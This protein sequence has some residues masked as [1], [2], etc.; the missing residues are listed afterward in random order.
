MILK[1]LP[2]LLILRAL[3]I[4]NK[5]KQQSGFDKNSKKTC[6][7][8]IVE[9]II[10]IVLF[11]VLVPTSLVIFVSA[12]KIVGQSYIQNQAAV[13]LGENNDILRYMRNLNFDLLVNGTFYMIRNP[14]TGSWLVKSDLPD[15]DIFERRI[16]VSNALRHTDTH[17]IY[18]DGDIGDS[19]EDSDTKKI[20]INVVWAPDYMPLDLLTHTLY[21]TDWQKVITYP[22][23]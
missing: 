6:G 14:G 19:Y 12:R 10:V 21:V 23:V 5:N 16:I 13:T 7:I 2:L 8:T 18:F 4:R 3:S 11:L 17:D 22:S 20:I 9:L 15:M 1:V